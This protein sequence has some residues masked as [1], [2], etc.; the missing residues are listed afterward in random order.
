MI[1][2]LTKLLGRLPIGWLQLQHNK[3]RLLAAVGG[4]VFANILIF[5]QLGFMGALFETSVL[6]HRSWDTDI[7]IA[8]SDFRTLR[9]ANTLPR[10]RMYQALAVGGVADAFPVYIKSIVWTDPTTNDTTNFR[11][12]A[13]PPDARAFMD[14]ELQSQVS[15]IRQP[16]TALVDRRTRQFN[17]AIS[18]AIE[19]GDNYRIEISGR[20]IDLTGLF[21][22]GASFDVDGSLIV[23]DQ[24][25]LRIFPKRSSGTP[26]L[27][28]VKCGEGSDPKI[29]AEAINAALPEGDAKAFTKEGFVKAEQDYQA[30]QTPIGFVFN[31]GVVIALIVGLVIVYQ[32]LTTDVQDHLSEYATFKAV[33]YSHG[34]FLGIIFEEALS[35]AALGFIPGLCISLVLYL[36]TQNA[37]ALPI[38]MPWSRPLIVFALTIAMCTLSGLIA[39]VRLARADPAELF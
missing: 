21:A 8:S 19:S 11:V 23:S 18:K 10:V 16:D 13:V 6:A 4:V 14:K 33:G 31:F 2:L 22:Q 5:M 12:I 30:G 35:L 15:S 26:T 34:F 37:T 38:A 28:F 27:I 24:T 25:F 1:T 3:T 39:T 17:E 20:R 32:V 7:V 36:V 9:E 29:V